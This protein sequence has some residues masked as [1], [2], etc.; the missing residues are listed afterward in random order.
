MGLSH[1]SAALVTDL[2]GLSSVGLRYVGLRYVGLSSVGHHQVDPLTPLKAA[3]RSP[4]LLLLLK[5]GSL[6]S[7][8]VYALYFI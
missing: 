2:V 3:E 1:P 6:I 8:F 4:I 5:R 7:R